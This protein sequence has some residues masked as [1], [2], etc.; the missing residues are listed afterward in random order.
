MLKRIRPTDDENWIHVCIEYKGSI[1]CGDTWCLGECGHPAL[2]TTGHDG[3][4]WKVHG[5]Q[6]ACGLVM[7][8]PLSEHWAGKVEEV[9]GTDAEWLNNAWWT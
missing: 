3:R 5:E 2:V 7:N 9:T 1:Y 6:V 4:L 8:K